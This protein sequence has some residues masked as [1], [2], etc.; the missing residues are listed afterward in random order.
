LNKGDLVKAID[1]LEKS[2]ERTD[3]CILR[4]VPDVNG[5]LPTLIAE[6]GFDDVTETAS[7]MTM[8]GTMSLLKAHK[9]G[10]ESVKC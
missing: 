8:L 5:L 10:A 4:G 7:Y 3:G 1:K 9:A 6:P 2:Q